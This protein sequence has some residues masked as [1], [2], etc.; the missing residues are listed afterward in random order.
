MGLKFNGIH[1]DT[2]NIAIN[3]D[4]IPLMAEKRQYSESVQG[5]DG[6]YIFEDGYDDIVLEF[7]AAIGDYDVYERRRNARQIALWLSGTGDLI[8]D[9]EPDVVYTVKKVVNGLDLKSTPRQYYYDFPIIFHCEPQQ[10]QLYPPDM[11]IPWG[12]LEV[13]WGLVDVPWGGYQVEF[14]VQNGSEI[15]LINDGTY[16]ALPII[17][18]SGEAEEVTVGE[19][20]YEDLDGDVYIDCEEGVVYSLDGESKVNKIDKYSSTYTDNKG[21]PALEPGTTTFEITGTITDLT[22]S[23]E[24]KNTYL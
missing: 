22:I 18:L 17:K 5:R 14:D 8:L 15:D 12:E 19:F 20:T 21:F 3:T 9:S 7:S 1:S 16:K 24:Y 13:P 4:K 10:E 23:F 6:Q 11:K 2:Y